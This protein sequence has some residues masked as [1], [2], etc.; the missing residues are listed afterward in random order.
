MYKSL[1]EPQAE[2]EPLLNE[3]SIRLLKKTIHTVRYLSFVPV[4]MHICC[5]IRPLLIKKSV[6]SFKITVRNLTNQSW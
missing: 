6:K 4:K 5:P 1:Q 2:I 3:E